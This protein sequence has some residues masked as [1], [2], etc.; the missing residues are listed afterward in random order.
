MKFLV[1]LSLKMHTSTRVNQIMPK[2]QQIIKLQK[3]PKSEKHNIYI[4]RLDIA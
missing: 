3:I 1:T 2:L 4:P